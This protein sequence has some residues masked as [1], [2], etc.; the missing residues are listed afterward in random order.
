MQNEPNRPA[1]KKP[2]QAPTLSY[3]GDV[4]DVVQGGEGKVS[5]TNADPGEPRKTRPSEP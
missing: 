3:M 2:W 4:E 5:V 1:Q